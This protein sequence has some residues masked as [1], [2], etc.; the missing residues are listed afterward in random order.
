MKTILGDQSP[1][2][3]GLLR[4]HALQ[5]SGID[6][7]YQHHDADL[8]GVVTGAPT[9]VSRGNPPY[10]SLA[11]RLPMSLHK[12]TATQQSV[13]DACRSDGC[14]ASV[15]P[16]AYVQ[17]KGMRT[18]KG[19]IHEVSDEIRQMFRFEREHLSSIRGTAVPEIS[20]ID[21]AFKLHAQGVTINSVMDMF[22]ATPPLLLDRLDKA[23]FWGINE[24]LNRVPYFP[25][26]DWHAIIPRGPAMLLEFAV[27]GLRFGVSNCPYENDVIR[28]R[29]TSLKGTQIN[30]LKI[31]FSWDA[32]FLG[33]HTS[34]GKI[35]RKKGQPDFSDV[36]EY[37]SKRPTSMGVRA[38]G[39]NVNH[40]FEECQW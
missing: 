13:I 8:P 33:E 25:R 34:I 22:R 26:S 29:D 32:D 15:H 21:E 4:A 6:Y 9:G 7:I 27:R 39:G 40:A 28:L 10:F 37:W 24:N 30:V 36:I 17:Y 18:I 35:W 38:F 12:S 14:R 20:S 1:W 31:K 2:N 23:H 16:V 5:K 11:C 3:G 19:S